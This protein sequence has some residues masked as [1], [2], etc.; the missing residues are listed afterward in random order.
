M[1]RAADRL[2]ICIV[3]AWCVL[4]PM[5]G[6]ESGEDDAGRSQREAVELTVFAASSLTDAFRAI[7]DGFE[8]A[9]PDVDVVL[10]FAGSQALRLQ[11]EQG[12]GADV[13]ASANRRHM[14]ALAE[15][16][17]VTDRRV[18]AHNELVGIVPQGN[19]AGIS[20]FSGLP[21]A[22]R[23]VIGSSTVPVGS[24]TESMLE[25][26]R[27]EFGSEFANGVR[28]STVST[29]NNVRLVRAKVELGE[30][31]AAIV[32]RTDAVSSEDVEVVPILRDVNVRASYYVGRTTSSSHPESAAEFIDFITRG[33][34]RELLENQGFVVETDSR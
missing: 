14:E 24:Y 18:M 32:Y 11:L 28:E 34:G 12:A 15:A 5:F 13:F 25:N 17:I 29:E 21:Q 4:F 16:N 8:Q 30:A 23:L 10:N 26:A 2:Q 31:D 22:E 27:A 3:V 6:C 7:E 9:H 20:D 19:P 33:D 1:F